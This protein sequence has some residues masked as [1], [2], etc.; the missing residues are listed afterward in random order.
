MKGLKLIP[1]IAIL[2]LL[3]TSCVST[4]KPLTVKNSQLTT[5]N[6]QMN[7]KVGQTTKN[8]VLE[9]FGSPNITTRDGSGQEVWS[10]QRAAQVAQASSQSGGFTIILAGASSSNSSLET[11]SS[12]VTLI[13]KFDEKDIVSDFKSRTSNF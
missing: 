12:M 11:S 13:I 1:A 4:N 2:L 8:D 3:T 6:I 10:Y 5:G 7:L 9:A